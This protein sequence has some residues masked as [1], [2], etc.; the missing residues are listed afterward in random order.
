MRIGQF[1]RWQYTM[2]QFEQVWY[3]TKAHTTGGR[4][5]AS[6]GVRR[7]SLATSAAA[8]DF[9]LVLLAARCSA[10]TVPAADAAAIVISP[11]PMQLVAAADTKLGGPERRRVGQVQ[12]TN[13]VYLRLDERRG[14]GQVRKA[15]V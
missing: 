13:G 10:H 3:T 6:R 1:F 5:G 4:D 12:M 15:S 9:G 14:S 8:G 7:S 11:L 2:P